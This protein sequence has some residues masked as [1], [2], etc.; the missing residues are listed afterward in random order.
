MPIVPI[1]IV[2]ARGSHTL[3]ENAIGWNVDPI[4]TVVPSVRLTASI[5]PLQEVLGF[6][7]QG[8]AATT[9]ATQ[10]GP[11]V[12]REL[13]VKLGELGRTMG[14]LPRKEGEGQA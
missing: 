11:Q 12:A 10:M 2:P 8:S 4:N 13:Y 3:Y 5:L 7:T 9:V 1:P 6:Q 14:W